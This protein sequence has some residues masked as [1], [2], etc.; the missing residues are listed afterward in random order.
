MV[1]LFAPW[2]SMKLLTVR[3]LP[4]LAPWRVPP[5]LV[6]VGLVRGKAVQSAHPPMP[7]WL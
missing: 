1:Q 5:A 4:A 3:V 2:R 7:V 6:G